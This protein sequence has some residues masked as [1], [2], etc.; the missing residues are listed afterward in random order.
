MIF[1]MLIR[2]TS[3]KTSHHC[4]QCLS[5]RACMDRT[6]IFRHLIKRFQTSDAATVSKKRK[7]P[8][9]KKFI[10]GLGIT[11]AAAGGAYQVMLDE[12]QRRKVRV[13]IGGFGR[14]YR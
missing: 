8:K 10:Y 3:T 7:F 2:S 13:T 4:M 14:F 1:H 9:T 11:S 5:Q 12:P 6:Q